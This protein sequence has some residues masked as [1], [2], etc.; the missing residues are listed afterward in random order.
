VARSNLAD[1]YEAEGRAADAERELTALADGARE[2]PAPL[3]RLADFYRRRG[4]APRARKAQA[5]AAR[6]TGAP[7]ALRPLRPASR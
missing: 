6:L 7:R 5:E 2:D 3:R 1:L 4:D